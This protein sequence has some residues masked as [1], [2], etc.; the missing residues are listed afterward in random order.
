MRAQQLHAFIA[1]SR[2]PGVSGEGG[3]R[4]GRELCDSRKEHV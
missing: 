3:N 2:E 1:P 4:L